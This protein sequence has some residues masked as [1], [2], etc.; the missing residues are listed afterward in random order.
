M[1]VV[2]IKFWF[3]VCVCKSV[4]KTVLYNIICCAFMCYYIWISVAKY[5]RQNTLISICW[6]SFWLLNLIRGTL[7]NLHKSPWHRNI[8]DIACYL[9]TWLNWI[10]FMCDS[11]VFFFFVHLSPVCLLIFMK[12]IGVEKKEKRKWENEWMRI[13]RTQRGER[14]IYSWC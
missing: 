3:G 7:L 6:C 8:L 5:L 12:W 14:V 4:H 9:F 2:E 13:D 1:S 10:I 11:C